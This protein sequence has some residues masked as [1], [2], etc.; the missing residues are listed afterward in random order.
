M[1]SWRFL[2]ACRTKMT[3]STPACSKRSRYARDLRRRPGRTPQPGAVAGGELRPESLLAERRLHLGRIALIAAPLQI[4]GPDIGRT[5]PVLAEDVVVPERVA[6]EVASLQA[7]V[8][9]H[10]LVGVTHHLGHA[11][12][13]GVHGEPDGNTALGQGPLVVGHP[14]LR[15]LGIDEGERQRADALLGRQQDGVAAGAGHPQWR[16]RPLHRLGH[17]VARRHLDEAPVDTGERR[18]RHATQR[19]LQPFEPG[20]A[21]GRRIDQDPPSSASEPDSPTRTRPGRR[22]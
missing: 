11:G 2:P 4:L 7:A 5:G 15:L 22:R 21:L 1:C 19:D 17:H 10:L 8:E 6:E 12:D 20:V 16:V 18:L 3:W 9:C 14:F 13:V